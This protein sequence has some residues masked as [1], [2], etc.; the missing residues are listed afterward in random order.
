MPKYNQEFAEKVH[1]EL[2]GDIDDISS[3][4]RWMSPYDEESFVNDV[5]LLK[6][7]LLAFEGKVNALSN[8]LYR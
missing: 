7:R 2:A 4:V 5:L 1:E 3:L 8:N 6:M